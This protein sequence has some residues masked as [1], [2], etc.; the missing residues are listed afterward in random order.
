MDENT[1]NKKNLILQKINFSAI[2]SNS[3]FIIGLLLLNWSTVLI[4][5][6]YWIEELIG[7]I[8]LIVKYIILKVSR[9]QEKTY[10]GGI[11]FAYAF[12]MFGHLVFLLI[13]FGISAAKDINAKLIFDNIFYFSK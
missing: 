7:F 2:F 1:Q 5:F 10:A 13:F 9:K 6:G 12:F 11:I 8:F 3:I 4:I